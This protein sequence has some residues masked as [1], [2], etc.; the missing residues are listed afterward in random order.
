M[1]FF[2]KGSN[3]Q[4]VFVSH[5]GAAL[6]LE[7]D[8]NG[9]VV[10]FGGLYLKRDQESLQVVRDLIS[11]LSLIRQELA[12]AVAKTAVSEAPETAVEIVMSANPLATQTRA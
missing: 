2:E 1:A 10:L 6:N 8:G 12:Y 4:Q 5:N 3:K 11:Q 7:T 9:A